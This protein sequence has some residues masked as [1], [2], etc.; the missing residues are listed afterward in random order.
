MAFTLLLDRSGS[1]ADVISDVQESAKSFLKDLPPSAECALASFNGSFSYHNLYFQNCNGG[2]FKL[3]T[4]S[5]EGGTDLYSPLLSAYESLSR[6]CFED[7]QK[8]VILITDGQIPSDD[9]T[10][11]ELL[12]AKNDTLTFVNFLGNK[13]DEQLIGLADAYLQTT[14]DIKSSLQQYFHSLSTAYGAQKVLVVKSCNGGK[15]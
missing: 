12:A 7:Y 6:E 10:K 4:L 9:E 5:A 15:P 11:K 1:M 8:A 2:D 13:N 3:Q 14:S